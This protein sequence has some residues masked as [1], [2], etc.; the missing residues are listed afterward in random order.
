MRNILL[1]ICFFVTSE[2]F[3]FF[4]VNLLTS[5]FNEKLVKSNK[6]A[7]KPIILYENGF[8]YINGVKGTGK[9]EIYT[10]IGNKIL[11]LNVQNLLNSKI[12]VLLK[13]RNMYII[14]IQIQEK[15]HTFKIIA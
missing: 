15:V 9:I 2:S 1:I 13:N 7:N 8:L 3:S 11:E 4:E 5:S 10:I 14:R 12:P 6:L